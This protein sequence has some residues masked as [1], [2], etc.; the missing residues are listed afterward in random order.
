LRFDIEGI[1]RLIDRTTLLM[2]I[3]IKVQQ[4]FIYLAEAV[5]KANEAFITANRGL[6]ELYSQLPRTLTAFTTITQTV[7][8]T[9]R[10]MTNLASATTSVGDAFYTNIIAASLQAGNAASLLTGSVDTLSKALG[11][12]AQTAAAMA[13]AVETFSTIT[14]RAIDAVVTPITVAT[15]S[16]MQFTTN[17]ERAFQSMAEGLKRPFEGIE[18]IFSEERWG[19]GLRGLTELQ[20]L[21]DRIASTGTSAMSDTLESLNRWLDSIRT[22]NLDFLKIAQTVAA[23]YETQVRRILISVQRELTTIMRELAPVITQLRD[24]QM[25]VHAVGM[26]LSAVLNIISVLLNAVAQFVGI[27]GRFVGTWLQTIQTLAQVQQAMNVLAIQVQDLSQATAAGVENFDAYTK[28]LNLV[29]VAAARANVSLTAVTETMQALSSSAIVPTTRMLNEMLDVTQELAVRFGILPDELM[30]SVE[31]FMQGQS[32]LARFHPALG[33]GAFEAWLYTRYGMLQLPPPLAAQA[34]LQ[35]LREAVPA[36]VGGAAPATLVQFTQALATLGQQFR[37]LFAQAQPV[38][39]I[40]LLQEIRDLLRELVTGEIGRNLRQFFTYISTGIANAVR[41]ILAG[42]R[43]LFASPQFQELGRGVGLLLHAI[44][45]AVREIINRITTVLSPQQIREFFIRLGANIAGFIAAS[46]EF[47]PRAI[48][49]VANLINNI[50]GGGGVINF[51]NLIIQLL[52]QGVRIGI[53][54]FELAYRTANE[55]FNA[56]RPMLERLDRLTRTAELISAATRMLL[57]LVATITLSV[58][59]GVVGGPI[60]AVIGLVTG[61]AMVAGAVKDFLAALRGGGL[62]RTLG[63]VG[64]ELQQEWGRVKQEI[65]NIKQGLSQLAPGLPQLN[66]HLGTFANELA[67]A[68]NAARQAFEQTSNAVRGALTAAAQQWASAAQESAA[69]LRRIPFQYLGNIVEQLWT[70]LEPFVAASRRLGVAAPAAGYVPIAPFGMP[71]ALQAPGG[72]FVLGGISPVAASAAILNVLREQL[73]YDI[74]TLMQLQARGGIGVAI[75]PGQ[76]EQLRNRL[77][78]TV[79]DM[80]NTINQGLSEITQIIDTRMNTIINNLRLSLIT[81]VAS[82]RDYVM[83]ISYGLGTLTQSLREVGFSLGQLAALRTLVPGIENTAAYTQAV[84]AH[85]E[86]ILRH[87]DRVAE[88]FV[89]TFEIT[90]R[91]RNLTAEIATYIAGWGFSLERIRGALLGFFT[92][93]IVA[94]MQGLSNALE[95]VR[96]NVVRVAQQMAAASREIFISLRSEVAALFA[97]AFSQLIRGNIEGFMEDLR[98]AIT[99]AFEMMNEYSQRLRRLMET[100]LTPVRLARESFDE[101]RG[102]LSTIGA[103]MA[104]FP[105]AINNLLPALMEARNI[106]MR[107][108][109]EAMALGD[110]L[111]FKEAHRSLIQIQR[112]I[113]EILGLGGM[114]LPAYT[115]EQM[116]RMLF[117]L[118]AP[119]AREALEA[120]RGRTLL[121]PAGF[122]AVPVP[123]AM[124]YGI[125][126]S[127]ALMLRPDIYGG[128]A[129]ALA[130]MQAITPVSIYQQYHR[131]LQET[132]AMGM[133]IAQT[134]ADTRRAA[135]DELRRGAMAG[136]A[137]GI[138]VTLAPLQDSM[139]QLNATVRNIYELLVRAYNEWYGRRAMEGT[140]PFPYGVGVAPWGRTG[141]SMPAGGTVVTIPALRVIVPITIEAVGPQGTSVQRTFYLVMSNR[142]PIGG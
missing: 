26:V 72:T 124:L 121:E 15:E 127:P 91:W 71:V 19:A 103:E 136:L 65:D 34:R 3:L 54:L 80:L 82:I 39:G 70:N 4:H 60:G 1:D 113:M 45:N 132:M 53:M 10:A 42:F 50:T 31:A 140:L 137:A 73:R 32:A 116:V 88:M 43:Q 141:F 75:Q 98:T 84:N 6:Q 59:G 117:R 44:G 110:V 109:Q 28:A 14:E 5:I 51:V 49:A 119:T 47:I 25:R 38:G 118:G 79:E 97:Q 13:E 81:G 105:Y 101:L 61:G 33:M 128:F 67:A 55:V 41:D 131:T 24:I 142:G 106:T 139:G 16:V 11:A 8:A 107:W 99:R 87:L 90:R 48:Q 63:E 20:N 104:L 115:P 21:M 62:G 133:G 18:N 12:G 86:S 9:T 27:L 78:R 89:R 83:G 74:A 17:I 40:Q 77:L 76:I 58:A 29:T 123:L 52:T 2:D 114:F 96:G 7:D 85:L 95:S 94:G 46:V 37:T 134:A 102:L 111:M 122:R 112:Q 68:G 92:G 66:E 120:A 108:M 125:P 35:F 135:I 23:Y 64:A 69:Q 129:A 138:G 30:R 22:I 56:V 130:G 36:L 126:Y 93:D 100:Y 57:G